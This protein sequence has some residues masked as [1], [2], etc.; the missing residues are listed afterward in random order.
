MCQVIGA[1]ALH[2]CR[3]R[4]FIQLSKVSKKTHLLPICDVLGNVGNNREVG[5]GNPNTRTTHKL[6]NMFASPVEQPQAGFV[7]VTLAFTLFA[8]VA[9]VSS[10]LLA[11]FCF[12]YW[13]YLH[14]FHTTLSWQ[15]EWQTHVA[16]S[17]KRILAL[18]F[19][20]LLCWCALAIVASG[21]P[22][23]LWVWGFDPYSTLGVLPTADK[24]TVKKAYRRLSMKYS[25][26]P[27]S[28]ERESYL[29][30][31]KAYRILCEKWDPE[32]I[33]DTAAD[34]SQFLPAAMAALLLIL[35]CAFYLFWLNKKKEG[36]RAG[37]LQ[38]DLAARHG[39]EPAELTPAS[40]C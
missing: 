13:A 2:P 3:R 24:S 5:R 25:H 35:S 10:L 8:V 14:E 4:K 21:E 34:S 26:Y 40:G 31:R 37:P 18:S 19:M 27:H 36:V 22:S 12:F 15:R 28:E 11:E 9:S 32:V 16:S 23:C 7:V 38:A 1:S 39:A 6:Y 30:V 17:Y 20:W 29:Q 33:D